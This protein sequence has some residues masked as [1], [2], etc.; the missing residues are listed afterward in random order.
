MT[1]PVMSLTSM[2]KYMHGLLQEML[3]IRP[4][5]KSQMSDITGVG[6]QKLARYGDVF[7]K[8]IARH[9]LPELLDNNLSDTKLSPHFNDINP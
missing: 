7:L 1:T 4:T 6:E 3:K 8:E 2:T 9:P 5:T